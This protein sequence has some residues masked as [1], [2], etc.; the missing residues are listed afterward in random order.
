[1]DNS[2]AVTTYESISNFFGTNVTFNVALTRILVG[3][4]IVGNRLVSYQAKANIQLKKTALE[5][6]CLDSN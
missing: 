5:Y 1:M 6:Q 4:K 2:K 3:F